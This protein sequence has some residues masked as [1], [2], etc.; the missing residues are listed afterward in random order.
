MLCGN[1]VS[2]KQLGGCECVIFTSANLEFDDFCTVTDYINA[3]ICR[4]IRE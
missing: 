3:S 2:A 1:V 4:K